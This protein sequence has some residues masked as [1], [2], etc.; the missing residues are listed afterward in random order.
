MC[1]NTHLEI[2]G[3]HPRNTGAGQAVKEFEKEGVYAVTV[4]RRKEF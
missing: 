1:S 4:M 2:K 3:K